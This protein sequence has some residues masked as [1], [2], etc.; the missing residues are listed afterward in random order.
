MGGQGGSQSNF[1][2]LV[3]LSQNCLP[4]SNRLTLDPP[5]LIDMY[6]FCA[7]QKYN[8][9]R[10]LCYVIPGLPCHARMLLKTKNGTVGTRISAVLQRKILSKM[11]N[12]PC[13][14][15]CYHLA[16]CIV[17]MIVTSDCKYVTV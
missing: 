10:Q 2:W 7:R 5:L 3:G 6:F 17:L 4:L 11:F 8:G 15:L 14:L 16:A 9:I 13:L 12:I 1:G